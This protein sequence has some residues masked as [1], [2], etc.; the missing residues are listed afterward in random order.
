MSRDRARDYFRRKVFHRLD[1]P[2][3]AKETN[4][5]ALEHCVYND[6]IHYCRS[7][8]I[9][10]S[11]ECLQFREL[12]THRILSVAY[13]LNHPKNPRVFEKLVNREISYPWLARA[14]PMDLYP[15]LW[16]SS[17]ESVAMK[18]LK[19]EMTVDVK[20]APDGAFTCRRCKSK[21]TAY[22]QMQTRS[23][24]CFELNHVCDTF[25][26]PSISTSNLSFS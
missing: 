19:R 25:L 4:A 9:P 17:I 3:G 13:N 5:R 7:R 10:R 22:Y 20:D 8:E 16:A 24:V 21:K 6:F 12:Y 23:A 1:I 14:E 26:T 18:R 2:E 11:W 15:E